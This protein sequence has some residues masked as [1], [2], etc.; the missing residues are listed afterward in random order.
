MLKQEKIR[1][2][3]EAI[4]EQAILLSRFNPAYKVVRS[5]G[6]DRIIKAKS[7]E[8]IKFLGEQKEVSIKK[9]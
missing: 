1:Q 4:I 6:L 3:I 7:L 9:E 5:T 2:G 8:V